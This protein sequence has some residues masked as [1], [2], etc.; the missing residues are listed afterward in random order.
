MLKKVEIK[1]PGDSEYL[2]GEVIDKKE[3]DKI[4]SFVGGFFI[5][6]FIS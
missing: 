5:E 6:F 1:E 4:N 3:L 2:L